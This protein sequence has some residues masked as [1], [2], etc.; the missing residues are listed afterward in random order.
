MELL[1]H[2]IRNDDK[3]LTIKLNH[4]D[5]DIKAEQYVLSDNGKILLKHQTVSMLADAIGINVGKPTLII[6]HNPAVYVFSRTVSLGD[7]EITEIGESNSAN[8]FDEVMK[9]NPATIAD[10]RA[11]ERAVLKL[12]G[13]Y[14]EVYGSSEMDF[15]DDK[16]KSAVSKKE[17]KKQNDTLKDDDDKANKEVEKSKA[18][19]P[20][21]TPFWWNDT[22]M[23][24][25]RESQ[26]D[27]EVAIVTQGP[28]SGKNWTVKQ[29]YD[30]QYKS[31]VFFA[32]RTNLENASD[33]FKIQVYACRRVIRKYGLK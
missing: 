33:D 23:G 16:K 20:D 31:C 18:A 17:P 27:P 26:L 11:Y 2:V 4:G 15:K 29:L 28:C 25:F 9:V 32:E 22:G 3:T 8:M 21:G 14:G 12:I 19:V 7:T 5:F 1:E 13:I 24:A 6:S 30:Y 10:N